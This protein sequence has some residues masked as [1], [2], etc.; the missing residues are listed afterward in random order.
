MKAFKKIAKILLCLTLATTF[1]ACEAELNLSA[2]ENCKTH[3]DEDKNGRCD[4]CDKAITAET[5]EEPEV[6]S[7]PETEDTTAPSD[8][9]D[10]DIE[11]E[12]EDESVEPEEPDVEIPNDSPSI[13]NPETENPEEPEKPEDSP[14]TKPVDPDAE[15]PDEAPETPVLPEDEENVSSGACEYAATRD[16]SGRE[17]YYVEMSVYGYGRITILLDATTAPVSVSNFVE[18]VKT[19]F[20]NGLTFHR[21]INDFMIQ[22]GDPNSDGTGG[23]DNEI[24]GEFSSNGHENDIS[25]IKGVISMARASDPDSASSQFFICNADASA[26]LDGNYAAFGYVVEGLDVID[27][28]TEKVFPKTAYSDYYNDFS[29]DPVYGMPKHYIWSYLGNGAINNNDDK[30]VIEY[31][32]LVEY[33]D[34]STSSPGDSLDNPSIDYPDYDDL[35]GDGTSDDLMSGMPPVSVLP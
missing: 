9:E 33:K 26:S 8:P 20:Y 6:P 23:S 17:I 32:K 27:E 24:Y 30:P 13:D 5:P 11:D 34:E 19:G 29:T 7:A 10:S 15:I 16:I 12:P 25:H 18:L 14:S 28:I 22:G 2:S 31:I 4:N 3:V 1:F 35:D 21:V